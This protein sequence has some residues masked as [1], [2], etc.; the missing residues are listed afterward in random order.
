MNIQVLSIL[1][2]AI[3]FAI[4]TALPVNIGALAFAAAFIVG[5]VAGGMTPAEIFSGFPGDLF[6]TLVGITYLFAIAQ[7]NG[8]IDLLVAGAVRL[9][10]GRVAAIPW[11]MFLVAAV[12]TALGALG[13][14]AVAILAPIALRFAAQHRIS[15]LMMGLMVI[16]GAQAGAFS[17]TSV[18]GGIVNG[19]V[20]KAGLASDPG[21]LFLSSLA[22]NFAIAVVVFLVLGGLECL[23]RSPEP[24][25]EVPSAP[26]PGFTPQI[27]ATLGG[28]IALAVCSLGLGFNVGLVAVTIA[29]GLTLLSPGEQKG[30]VDKISWSTVL[31]ICGVITYVAVM[32]KIGAVD[33][34]GKA[35]SGLPSPLLAGLLLC[36]TAAVV[37]AF[38]SSTALLGVLI[39]LGAPL[40]MEGQIG[41]VGL[42]CAISISTTI[43]DTSPFST[44]G[45]LVVAN[46]SA[47]ERDR[48]LRGLLIYTAVIAV[49]GP[50]LAYGLLVLPG[51]L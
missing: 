20:A 22:F 43:V 49:A 26:A 13:P 36:F 40:L 51:L 27:I 8:T 28:L 1:V 42:V 30:A 35:I 44:N 21:A 12:L 7:K 41:A 50:L 19:V 37:S 46:A 18:Y 11:I 31:L 17:P 6:V 25:P 3:M 32:Q 15:P 14:A 45:A 4:A 23:R 38:A 16:H 47:E 29:V 9:V 24:A 39:P 34:T 2:L 5:N 10:R 48:L 33:L